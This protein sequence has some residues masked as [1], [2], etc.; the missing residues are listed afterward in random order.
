MME[1]NNFK[2]GDSWNA[3][4]YYLDFE[5]KMREKY[6]W[7]DFREFREMNVFLALF[8]FSLISGKIKQENL[9]F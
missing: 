9:F 3:V 5:K 6:T 4:T 2:E 1:N 8:S 7:E